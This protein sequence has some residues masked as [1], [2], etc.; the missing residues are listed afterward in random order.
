MHDREQICGLSFPTLL[1]ICSFS[2][3][4]IMA[5]LLSNTVEDFPFFFWREGLWWW[6]LISSSYTWWFDEYNRGWNPWVWREMVIALHHHILL[7]SLMPLGFPLP[8]VIDR[9][10]TWHLKSHGCDLGGLQDKEFGPQ[11]SSYQKISNLKWSRGKT[12]CACSPL[13]Y[14]CELGQI[15]KKQGLLKL[16]QSYAG[17]KL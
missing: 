6:N 12:S 4:E 10:M 15:I 17:S 3:K 13:W 14:S 2:T 7:Y 5:Y 9:W 16:E 8:A 11:G 1:Y